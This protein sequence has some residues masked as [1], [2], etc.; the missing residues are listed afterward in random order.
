[1]NGFVQNIYKDCH[2]LR[3][4]NC[5]NDKFKMIKEWLVKNGRNENKCNDDKKERLNEVIWIFDND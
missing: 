3:F 5:N 1:M 4:T 2:R